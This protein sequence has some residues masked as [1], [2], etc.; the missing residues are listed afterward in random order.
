[1]TGGGI[2]YLDAFLVVAGG[3]DAGLRLDLR[4][5]RHGLQQ[6]HSADGL[7]VSAVSVRERLG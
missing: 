7:G 4:E 1:M 5:D 2:T 3:G 6:G